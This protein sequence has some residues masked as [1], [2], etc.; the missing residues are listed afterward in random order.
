MSAYNLLADQ[1]IPTCVLW[2]AAAKSKV[3][4]VW[5][6][7]KTKIRILSS[8][9]EPTHAPKITWVPWTKIQRSAARFALNDHCCTTSVTHL[10]HKWPLLYNKCH[11][12]P[13]QMIT[14]VQQ[15]SHT[16]HTNDHCCTTS[17][18]HLPHK[19]SL[20]YNKCHTPPTQTSLADIRKKTITTQTHFLLQNKTW[21]P[22]HFSAT[23]S[24]SAMDPY[25]KQWS[26]KYIQIHAYINQY[27]YSFYPRLIRAWNLFPLI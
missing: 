5:Y 7:S 4:D 25:P 13:T 26:Y 2:M 10:P 23:T 1:E 6:V 11:T 17:V 24:S 16:S 3:K 8:S 12:P 27:T 9:L 18:T 21:S 15:V 22:Q 19:W 14:A 20:L